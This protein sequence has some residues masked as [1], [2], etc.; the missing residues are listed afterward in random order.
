MTQDEIWRSDAENG[1]LELAE[2]WLWHISPHFLTLAPYDFRGV[3]HSFFGFSHFLG[4]IVTISGKLVTVFPL[5]NTFPEIWAIVAT[6]ALNSKPWGTW[7]SDFSSYSY[8]FF[9]IFLH[10]ILFLLLFLFFGLFFSFFFFHYCSLG[11]SHIVIF[12]VVSHSF[13]VSSFI[14]SFCVSFF[15]LWFFITILASGAHVKK[16][17]KEHVFHFLTFWR[18]FEMFFSKPFMVL[19][20]CGLLLKTRCLYF[21]EIVSRW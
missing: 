16:Q 20:L 1:I 9:L 12:A 8:V 4:G 19:F 2:P 10:L 13:I 11:W 15:F 18:L 7:F 3:S 17:R 5:W 14:L 21:L 6:G